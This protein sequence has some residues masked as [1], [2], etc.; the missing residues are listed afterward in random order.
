LES[1][2]SNG[3]GNPSSLGVVLD[4]LLLV[5]LYTNEPNGDS[6]VDERGSG[7]GER[8]QVSGQEEDDER[9]NGVAH[10]QQKG[11]E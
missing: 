2:L 11:Y 5:I 9:K 1:V 3:S 10:L 7:P 6:S 4:K 8:N